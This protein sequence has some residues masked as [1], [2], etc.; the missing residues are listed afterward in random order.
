MPGT[1][2]GHIPDID[3]I[4]FYSE[5]N[6]T[7][8]AKVSPWTKA[9]MLA[10][11]VLL[12]T[13]AKS[14]FLLGALYVV[15]LLI[16]AASG[17]PVRKLFAWYALPLIFVLSLV[18]LM[19]WNV[20]GNP[21]FSL[22]AYGVRMTLSDNGV[23]LVA[24]LLLKALISVTFSLFFLMTTKYNHFSTMIYKVFPSPIDQIFLMS[25]RFIFL[26]MKMVDAMIKALRSRGSGLIA[27]VV[28][29]G[30]MF[31]E[32]FALV[33]IRSYDRAE[34]VNKAMESRGF[35]GKYLAATDIP[36]MKAA[37]FAFVLI[38]LALTV[39]VALRGW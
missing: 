28:R 16:Y 2:S 34:R 25:Y 8:F 20:P 15:V 18:L 19:M 23:L 37:D 32:V 24:R 27:G 5:N 31:A 38:S 26:T 1:I 3:L 30:R 9:L 35:S 33:F 29:Q 6:R 7:F 39:Y 17:L 21:I 13:V 4:T 12:I 22:E 10:V 14:M 11:V 36:P